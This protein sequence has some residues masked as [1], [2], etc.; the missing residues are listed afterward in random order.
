[1]RQSLNRSAVIFLCEVML[2]SGML[3]LPF[4]RSCFAQ[5]DGRM[6]QYMFNQL[7]FNP[8]Y[9]GSQ[10][11]VN[12]YAIARQQ[13][14]GYGKGAPQTFFVNFDIPF[15]YRQ[16]SQ[17]SPGK[18]VQ[19]S[20]GLGL[21]LMRDAIGFG[22]T[23]GVELSYS[24]RFHLRALGS[25]AFGLGLRALNDQFKAQWLTVDPS[26]N[27]PA[28]PKANANGIAFD[29]SFGLYYTARSMY[30]GVSGQ[31]LLGPE[32]RSSLSKS[33]SKTGRVNY[34]RQYYMVG[35]YDLNVSSRWNLEPSFL[36]RTDLQQYLLSLTL[37]AQYNNLFWFGVSYH[38]FESVGALAGIKLF[39]TFRIGY[40]YD[41]P[42]GAMGQ[43]TSG[44]HEIIVG[45]S[46]GFEKQTRPQ[47]YKSIR[48]L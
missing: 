29:V 31:N 32:L 48:Y 44:S 12:V 2:V 26:D 36:A 25:L 46:F 21:H 30:F 5:S 1:M 17:M 45:Y 23:N 16:L 7:D 18:K 24:A 15:S 28:I 42:T 35:G 33:V 34:A 43:F 11:L 3:L 19:Y 13:W 6:R 9:A 20:H 41:Y 47:Q 10:G 27:D 4:A 22:A 14:V 8:G 37:A 38:V 39:D 40:S